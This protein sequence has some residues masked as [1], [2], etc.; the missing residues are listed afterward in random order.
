[1]TRDAFKEQDRA[2]R[3]NL[4]EIDLLGRQVSLLADYFAAL[5][6]LATT[7]APEPSA[8]SSRTPSRRSMT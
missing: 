5:S 4:T 3:L 1:V 7:K 2:L 8:P 6:R